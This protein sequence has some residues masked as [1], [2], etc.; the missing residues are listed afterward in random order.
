MLC[1][2][3][4]SFDLPISLSFL[5]VLFLFSL[6]DL[7]GFKVGVR[8]SELRSLALDLLVP[9]DLLLLLFKDVKLFLLLLMLLFLVLGTDL[10]ILDSR[11]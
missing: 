8:R 6:Q 1:V 4:F 5:E 3:E 9:V 2:E 7:F 11:G 10:L